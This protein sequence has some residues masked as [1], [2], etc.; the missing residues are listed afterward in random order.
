MVRYLTILYFL[1]QVLFFSACEKAAVQATQG[2]RI[3]TGSSE[4]PL[5]EEKAGDSTALIT[6]QKVSPTSVKVDWTPTSTDNSADLE[7]VVYYSTQQNIDTYQDALANG[8]EAGKVTGS[9]TSIF[10]TNLAEDQT[11]YFNVFAINAAEKK[12]ISYSSSSKDLS[13]PEASADTTAPSILSVSVPSDSTYPAG[14]GLSFTVTM[15]ES[16]VVTGSPRI[17][18]DINGSTAYAVYVSGSGSKSLVF[19]YTVAS[20]QTDSDGIG[21]TASIDLN[22]GTIKDSAGNAATLTFTAADTSGILVDS[23]LPTV[24]SV[25]AP[26][27][28]T[29]VSGDNL[30]F[31]VTTD[32]AVSVTGT[33]RIVLDIGSS[34]VY[35]VYTSSGSSTSHTFRYTVATSLI[36]ADGISVS[37][38]IDLN[39]G[40]ITDSIGNGLDLTFTAPTTTSVLVDSTNPSVSSLSLASNGS[41]KESDNLDFTVNFNE[42]VTV[43]GTPRLVLTVGA[44][45][46]YATY[47]SGSASSALVFRYS[48]GSGENDSDGIAISSTIDLNS[49]TIKDSANNSASLSMS[50]GNSSGIIVDTTAPSVSSVTAPSD[51]SYKSGDSVSTSIAF[52]EAVTVTGTPRISIAVGGSTTYATYASGSATNTLV[53][54]Y[55][56]GGSDND[57]DGIVLSS[58]IELNSGTIK[59]SAGND[60]ALT[61]S[62]P[63]TSSVLVDTTAP[64]T[65][66]ATLVSNGDYVTSSSISVT[67]N[68]DSTVVVTG[69]PYVSLDIGGS[70]KQASY[71]SGSNST[72]LV[73]TYSVAGGDN[74]Q[75]GISVSSPIVLN[76]GT[77]KD[78]AGN[79]SALTFSAP[80]GSGITVNYVNSAPVVSGTCS[81]TGTQDVAYTCSPSV[82]DSDSGDT[83]T[84]SLDSTNDCAWA[85]IDSST[86]AVSGT[87]T[88]EQVGSCTLAFKTNDTHDDSN[89]LTT[90][91]T[92]ANVAPTLSISNASNIMKGASSVVIRA[93]GDVAASEEGH[94]VYSLNNAATS[95]PKC[96]DNSLGLSIDSSTG[97][98]TFQPAATYTGTCYIKVQFDDQN[99]SSNTEMLNLQSQ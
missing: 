91:V 40:T 29:Y 96:S 36:D 19:T 85:S 76:S 33:P 89:V 52:D 8:S 95:S 99:A 37:S 22:S 11:Y 17:A 56:V 97:A 2:E 72:A 78:V 79:D 28:G 61:F 46:K 81:T 21:V 7:Y 30:D 13:A 54:T 73:F 24:S 60:S 27:N 10:V 74:D 69:T 15:S 50:V 87:P 38:P 48:V 71:A 67:V 43:T 57:S 51:G 59:D 75:D 39:S 26:S 3:A 45:T 70:T 4:E 41:Y 98:V 68:F 93:D 84:W 23:V 63:D 31:V 64:A 32:T 18:L 82:N 90:S 20:G 35:A 92:I 94:G 12:V 42:N 66:S 86:G 49:G 44:A 14:Q 65:S 58:P 77:I 1:T 16:V 34:T 9:E 62:V 25:S 88:D 5:T 83:Q 80:D 47:Q 6:V 55:S 53:F